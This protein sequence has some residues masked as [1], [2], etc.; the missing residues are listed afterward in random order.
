MTCGTTSVETAAHHAAGNW[1]SFKSFV[2][3][4]EDELP[5]SR[6]WAIYYT[7]HRDSGLRDRSNARVIE[8]ALEPFTKGDD[9]DVVFEFH[10]HWTVGQL[11]GFSIRV[12]REGQITEAFR[13]YHGL[14]ERLS[15]HPIL[16]E[17]HYSGRVIDATLDNIL[18]HRSRLRERWVLPE[19]WECD[20]YRWLGQHL[21]DSLA[22]NDDQGGTPT[23]D[24]VVAAVIALKYPAVTLA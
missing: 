8:R 10:A 6:Q 11:N 15:D 16:D 20:V 22:N 21:P 2:W 23:H 3:D 17:E 24:Q 13:I 19:L 7:H 9:P 14:M 12:L 18:D 4:R 1:L 5:D